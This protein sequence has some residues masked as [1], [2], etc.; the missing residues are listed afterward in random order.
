VDV[1]ALHTVGAPQDY[2]E[3]LEA[4]PWI[5]GVSLIEL[6][7]R[8]ER[9]FAAL[10]G[11]P[12]IAGGY[13]GLPGSVA[14]GPGSV[15]LGHLETDGA[16]PYLDAGQLTVLCCECGEPGCWPLTTRFEVD[17]LWVVWRDFAQPHR[18]EW[19]LGGLGPFVF[20]RDQYEHAVTGASASTAP[21]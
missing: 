5:N 18:Y 12:E 7:R 10:E 17:D 16:L 13:H 19:D 1:L 6:A 11:H 3:P 21:V 15:L 4:V 2:C 14:L 20:D 9:P 8:V